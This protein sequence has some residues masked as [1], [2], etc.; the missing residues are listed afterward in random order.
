MEMVSMRAKELFGTALDWAVAKAEGY[1]DDPES[2]LYGASLKEVEASTFRPR[3]NWSVGGPLI[4]REKIQLTPLNQDNPKYGWAAAYKDRGEW[5]DD[6]Y[7]VHRQ[8]GITPLVA[9]MRCFVAAK[10]GDTV[11]V[12]QGLLP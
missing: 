3:E 4:E 11:Q 5:G 10:L 7:S 1:I 8:R 9:A 2:W 12:P 6:L